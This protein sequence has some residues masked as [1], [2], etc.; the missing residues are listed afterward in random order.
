L[1]N[2]KKLS[3]EE[4]RKRNKLARFIKEHPSEG[5]AKRFDDLLNNMTHNIKPK[6]PSK[7]EK[8]SKKG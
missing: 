1:P 2:N 5:D 4:A 3:L 7:D 6:K 8:T